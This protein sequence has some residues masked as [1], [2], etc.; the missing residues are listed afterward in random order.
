MGWFLIK[1]PRRRVRIGWS[2]SRG[3]GCLLAWLTLLAVSATLVV[4]LGRHVARAM[5]APPRS[6]A[7]ICDG[8]W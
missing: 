1:R 5:D 7:A 2:I 3:V 8:R 4:T 6:P